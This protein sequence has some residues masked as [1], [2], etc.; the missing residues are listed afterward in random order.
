MTVGLLV[1][2][3]VLIAN[4]VLLFCSSFI[5][6]TV[7]ALNS[8]AVV[9]SFAIGASVVVVVVVVVVDFIFFLILSLLLL[10]PP[11]PTFGLFLR[12]LPFLF[13]LDGLGLAVV[14]VVVVVVLVVV[15]VV[16]DVVVVVVVVVV[17]VVVVK[18]S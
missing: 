1:V 7:S 5:I 4:A 10:P 6:G 9:V 16:V 15:V 2:V 8:L 3:L 14:E 13:A 17:E 11:P 12:R 18:S